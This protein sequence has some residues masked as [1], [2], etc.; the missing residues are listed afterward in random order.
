MW[1]RRTPPR[2][3]ARR[4]VDE[5]ATAQPGWSVTWPAGSSS[6]SWTRTCQP[7]VG[8]GAGG[9]DVAAELHEHAHADRVGRPAGGQVGGAGLRRRAEVELRCR[10][11]SS[12]L[13]PY[14]WTWRQPGTWWTRLTGAPSAGQQL[15]AAV[16]AEP[17]VRRCRPSGRRA[18]RWP[19]RRPGPCP[20]RSASSGESRFRPGRQPP[21]SRSRGGSASRRAR[22][23]RARPGRSRRPTPSAAGSVTTTVPVVLQSS[24]R[25]VVSRSVIMSGA[26][27]GRLRGGA[28]G[29]GDRA[30]LLRRGLVRRGG[31]RRSCCR[32][33][34]SPPAWEPVVV[35]PLPV[36]LPVWLAGAV[37]PVWV[38]RPRPTAAPRAL[39]TLS[40]ARPA[41]RRR[42]RLMCVMAS[43]SAGALCLP[44][45]GPGVAVSVTCRQPANPPRRAAGAA[46]TRNRSPTRPGDAGDPFRV[47]R[48]RPR[49]SVGG[50]RAVGENHPRCGHLLPAR[51]ADQPAARRHRGGHPRPPGRRR[52]RARPA[53][54]KTTQLPKI[55]LELGRG[56]RCRAGGGM[57]GHTQPRRIAAR[58]VAER[59][60]EELGTDAGRRGRLPG[61]LH[62]PDL[63]GA[64]GSR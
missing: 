11:G 8:T 42:L 21:R 7:P 17:R 32:R 31:A 55:C 41:W 58:S 64:P 63:A 9:R 29:L 46:E 25:Y 15:D 34:P 4:T 44:C 14:R 33:S 59:I 56:A 12:S 20:T 28:A 54:G 43:P 27:R 53:P 35:E 26:A 38:V 2:R 16:V 22:R 24:K 13:S 10:P 52:R 5:V 36:P 30:R 6:V 39:T 48:D 62:R 23:R 18:R 47:F 37:L 45:E 57:I 61:P 50:R 3:H 51:A 19:R 60:A 1:C 40:P 49:N